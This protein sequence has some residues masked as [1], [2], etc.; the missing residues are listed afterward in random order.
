MREV[1]NIS[2]TDVTIGCMLEEIR[3]NHIDIVAIIK[4]ELD[5]RLPDIIAD[6][7]ATVY[8]EHIPEGGCQ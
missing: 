2:C 7:V 1:A 5:E 6:I 4:E 8:H 3:A